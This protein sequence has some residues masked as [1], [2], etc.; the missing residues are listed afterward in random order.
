MPRSVLNA[1]ADGHWDFEPAEVDNQQFDSTSAL[2][3][4]EE[5]VK[6][7]AERL[8]EGLPLWHPDDRRS[9]DD[10]ETAID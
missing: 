6:A 10:L 8:G 9:Y 2:P 3:G 5:K 1:I 4:S 7:L